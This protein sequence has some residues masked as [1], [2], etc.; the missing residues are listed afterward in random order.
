[1]KVP[2]TG[3]SVK[4]G[5]RTLFTHI[6]AVATHRSSDTA[7]AMVNRRRCIIIDDIVKPG[8]LIVF[9]CKGASAGAQFP[10]YR[11]V[12]A[13]SQLFA[14]SDD[15]SSVDEECLWLRVAMRQG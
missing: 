12:L 10:G 5:K 8:P 1:M 9:R 3:A 2:S 7:D 13:G 6:A 11:D 14:A 15:G 4:S